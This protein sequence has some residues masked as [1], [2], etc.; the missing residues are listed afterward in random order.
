M[1]ICTVQQ[2][3]DAE[4][5]LIDSGVSDLELMESVAYRIALSINAFFPDKQHCIAYLGKGN[6]AG[7][8]LAVL[9]YLHEKGWQVSARL[10]YPADA[11]EGLV[12]YQYERVLPF[13]SV[14][15][16]V[17]QEPGE[18]LLLLD[19]L[20]GLGAR[21]PLS[22]EIRGLVREMNDLRGATST[23]KTWAIDFPTGLDG[24][25]GDF[26][27]E[28]VLVADFT[29]VIGAVKSGMV[30]DQAIPL[31]GRLVPIPLQGALFDNFRGEYLLEDRLF[32]RLLRPRRYDVHKYQVGH[33][34]IIAG[35]HGMLGAAK[36]CSEAA[37]KSGAGMVT[38]HCL[39]SEYPTL[40]AMVRPEIIV[41]PVRDYEEIDASRY[42]SVLIGPGLG[43]LSRSNAMAIGSILRNYAGP[44]VLDADGLTFA[45]FEKCYL[46][47]NI[48]VTP[49]D[50]ELNRFLPKFLHTESR[51]EK[52]AYFLKEHAAAILYKGARTIVAKS[53]SPIYFNGSGNP[54]MA[55]AGQ[56]DVLAGVCAAF[57]AQKLTPLM[58]GCLGAHL[59][60]CASDLEIASGHQTQ[61]SL[62]AMDT[63]N[64]LPR[65]MMA[66]GKGLL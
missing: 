11:F 31:V 41:K 58:S 61:Y 16:K 25:T 28:A 18:S 44:I 42:D 64:A 29:S 35:S 37:L 3:K 34:G 40:A 5:K 30:E 60:G 1:N 56:G 38:L 39:E 2:V 26:E 12:K 17:Q 47:E 45:A 65:A 15:D 55:T 57:C 4:Q 13:L 54:G 46:K 33:V 32:S 27:E 52:L 10:A 36:L 53:G 66:V 6:N 7:D 24:D 20:L 63:L 43:E 21:L 59:C 9:R 50:G 22:D 62:T 49:H 23:V 14:L 48:L 19:G 8:A 51:K